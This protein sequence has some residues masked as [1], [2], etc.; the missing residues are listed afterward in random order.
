MSIYAMFAVRTY[1]GAKETMMRA[2]NNPYK[3]VRALTR[4]IDIMEALADLGWARI[5]ALSHYTG[6]DR[7]TLYRLVQTL[8]NRGYVARREEDGAVSLASKVLGLSDGVR[9]DDM[10]VQ[11]L[12]P[13]LTQL[14]EKILWPSDFGTL[15]GGEMTIAASTHKLSPLSIH[16]NLIGKT[17]PLLRSALGRAYLGALSLDDREHVLSIVRRL[18][19]D[20][21]ND[22]RS[23]GNIDALLDEVRIAG[24]ATSVGLVE[25][26]ISAIAM[27][28]RRG[29][30]VVGAVNITFFRSAMAPTQAARDYLEPLRTVIENCESVLK[31]QTGS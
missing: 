12:T 5:G 7:A 10:I 23:I 27:P 24:F 31:L 4:G 2:G 15:N 29:L 28:L 19:G 14:T 11:A 1:K 22:L 9:H 3:E 6:I 25:D 16:R 18:G 20:D 13:I 21:A 30:R 26:N 17:R 8:E